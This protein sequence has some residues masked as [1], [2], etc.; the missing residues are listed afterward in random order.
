MAVVPKPTDPYFCQFCLESRPASCERGFA[1]PCGHVFDATCLSVWVS[2]GVDE[3]RVDFTCQYNYDLA[4]GDD[5]T[6]GAV[7]VQAEIKRVGHLGG[8]CEA[9]V[10]NEVV[11]RLL[12]S[13]DLDR[14]RRFRAQVA[15]HY[16]L[17]CSE[18]LLSAPS[19]PTLNRPRTPA[20]EP[21]PFAASSRAGVALLRQRLSAAPA[22]ASFAS[23]TPTRTPQGP[24]KSVLH[25]RPP[26][27]QAPRIG[28][29]RLRSPPLRVPAPA[30][31]F[32]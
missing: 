28:R 20:F 4:V 25:T 11:E 21:A 9:A 19:R 8:I 27:Q 3:G 30:A 32:A 31:A 5:P 24:L 2:R 10:S 26:S 22:G 6:N 29:R 7:A 1:L 23:F 17:L 14:F 13:S 15:K 18:A 16:C 12:Q